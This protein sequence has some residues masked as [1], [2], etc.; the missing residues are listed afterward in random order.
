MKTQEIELGDLLRDVVTGFTGIAVS[1]H[2][3]LTGCN[4]W[5]LQPVP[6]MCKKGEPITYKSEVTA[7]DEPQLEIVEK[8]KVKLPE[9]PKV[10]D[11]PEHRSNGGPVSLPAERAIERR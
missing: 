11:E 1:K 7:F 3:F 2:V 6:K 8:G 5:G 9:R 10:K 4:R